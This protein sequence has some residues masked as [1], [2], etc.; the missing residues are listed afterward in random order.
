MPLIKRDYEKL[1][2]RLDIE[3]QRRR[4]GHPADKQARMW[5]VSIWLMDYFEALANE[6]SDIEALWKRVQAKHPSCAPADAGS[7]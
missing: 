1:Q 4:N 6:M 7:V 2:R 3:R 5:I